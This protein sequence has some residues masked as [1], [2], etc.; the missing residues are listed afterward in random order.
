MRTI[1]LLAFVLCLAVRPTQAQDTA[2]DSAAV[3][4]AVAAFDAAV[5]AKDTATAGRWLAADYRYFTS[6]G[7]VWSRAQLLKLFAAPAYRVEGALRSELEPRIT[8]NTAV[9]SSRWQGHGTYP[10]GRFDD[11]QRCSLVLVKHEAVWRLLS[12]H[13]TQIRPEG[14]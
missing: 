1:W 12:E 7:A 10:G 11:D 4:H 9:V 2:T 6:T 14:N 3:L 5:T 13:C 8:G